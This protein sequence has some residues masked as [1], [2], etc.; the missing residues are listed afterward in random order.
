MNLQAT[1]AGRGGSDGTAR[2]IAGLNILAAEAAGENAQEK[3]VGIYQGRPTYRRGEI[4]T[5]KSI[6]IV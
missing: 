1:G 2:A 5:A 3:R 4:R 6:S